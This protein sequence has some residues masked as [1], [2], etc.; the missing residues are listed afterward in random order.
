MTRTQPTVRSVVVRAVD[1][2]MS[3]ALHTSS[4]A[5]TSATC[6]R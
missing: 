1:A 6:G 3:M 4:G 5:L 2:P